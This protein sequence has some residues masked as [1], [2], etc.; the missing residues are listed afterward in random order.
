MKKLFKSELFFAISS[1]IIVNGSIVILVITALHLD[2]IYF[3]K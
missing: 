3:H 2:H 1:F